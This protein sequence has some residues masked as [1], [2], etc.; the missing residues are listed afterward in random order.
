ML[1][2]QKYSIVLELNL[3]VESYLCRYVEMF[4]ISAD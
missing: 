2:S 1:Y 4:E 3:A